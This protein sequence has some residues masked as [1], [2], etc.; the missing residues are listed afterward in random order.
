R[1]GA[2][3]ERSGAEG[4]EEPVAIIAQPKPR[5]PPVLQAAG[6]SGS[7]DIQFVV[8][9]VGRPEP[10]SWHVMGSTNRAFEDP[11]REAIMAARFHP[12]RLKGRP[13]RQLVAQR[14][15][16]SIDR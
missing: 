9:S 2:R 16:F 8:D 15:A 6:I 11:T 1:A 3:G 7:V 10:A 5:Y 4:V 13:V 12:A 14:I